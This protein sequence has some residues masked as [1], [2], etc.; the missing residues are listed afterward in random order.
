MNYGK[1]KQKFRYFNVHFITIGYCVRRGCCEQEG[2]SKHGVE[3]LFEPFIGGVRQN[4]RAVGHSL[5]HQDYFGMVAG[6]AAAVGLVAEAKGQISAGD[7]GAYLGKVLGRHDGR[8]VE[9]AVFLAEDLL[10]KGLNVLQKGAVGAAGVEFK[11][12]GEPGGGV[13]TEPPSTMCRPMVI[14]T[15]ASRNRRSNVSGNRTLSREKII[16]AVPLPRMTLPIEKAAVGQIRRLKLMDRI[17][18]SFSRPRTNMMTVLARMTHLEAMPWRDSVA[19][20]SM[21]AAMTARMTHSRP[22]SFADESF[23]CNI[24]WENRRIVN[25]ACVAA[26]FIPRIAVETNE[27]LTYD[28]IQHLEYGIAMV[29]AHMCEEMLVL[30]KRTP[31]KICRVSSPRLRRELGIIKRRDRE[32]EGQDLNFFDCVVKKARTVGEDA[33]KSAEHVVALIGAESI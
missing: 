5:V 31:D 32:L 12:E 18:D 4:S 1:S 24:D 13:V 29:P 9:I 8:C 16:S 10:H 7:A 6:I 30:R 27:I 11:H 23:V 21:V 20:R 2:S 19:M 22:V 26:G 25:E 33:A 14:S 28:L 3:G 15:T 17:S